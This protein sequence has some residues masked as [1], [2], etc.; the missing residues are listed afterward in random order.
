MQRHKTR[1]HYKKL[2]DKIIDWLN[3]DIDKDNYLDNK[4]VQNAIAQNSADL[5]E[6][7]DIYLDGSDEF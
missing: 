6:K 1:L 5:K 7:I 2:V 4:E 3:S